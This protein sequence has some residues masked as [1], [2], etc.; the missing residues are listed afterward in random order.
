MLA[1]GVCGTTPMSSRMFVVICWMVTSG[2][3]TPSAFSASP[4]FQWFVPVAT[5]S[6]PL[7]AVYFTIDV[8]AVAVNGVKDAPFPWISSPVTG[9]P[10]SV[11]TP[12]GS[13]PLLTRASHSQPTRFCPRVVEVPGACAESA[14]SR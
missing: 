10:E 9:D 5:T 7:G 12:A 2:S 14:V 8:V 1:A 13:K 4:R 6:A 3:P 11:F